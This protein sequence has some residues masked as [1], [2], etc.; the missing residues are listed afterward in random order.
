MKKKEVEKIEE[1]RQNIRVKKTLSVVQCDSEYL[2]EHNY[3]SMDISENGICLLSTNRIEIG[4]DIT[5]G[6]YLPESK[7][8]VVATGSVVRRNETGDEKYPYLVGIQFTQINDTDYERIQAHIRYY[9][10][11]E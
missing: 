8:P 7:I 2:L 4:E 6:I 10:L 3:L 9:T 1:R 5:L 11:Q